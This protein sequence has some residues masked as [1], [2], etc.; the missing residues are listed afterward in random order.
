M[1]RHRPVAW[2][3]DTLTAA[4]CQKF[5]AVVGDPAFNTLWELLAI[6][7]ALRLWRA[8]LGRRAVVRVKSDNIGALTTL[9]HLRP[10][11][12]ASIYWPASWRLT[13]LYS[14]RAPCWIC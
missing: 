11:S 5:Q 2:F 13:W 8:R 1:H 12:Q 14:S 3:A 9:L 10:R 7:V 6:V 4:D